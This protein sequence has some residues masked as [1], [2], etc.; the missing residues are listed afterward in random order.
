[1]KPLIL[2]LAGLLLTA[3]AP[4]R[5]GAS[6]VTSG[7]TNTRGYT[8]KIWSDGTASAGSGQ[9]SQ[10]LTRRFFADLRAAMH[11]PQAPP[12]ACMKSASFGTA[13][14]VEYHGWRSPDLQC[15]VSSGLV[16]LQRDVQAI[17]AALQ[18]SPE[19]K[20]APS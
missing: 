1:M 4:L 17:V 3:A 19:F 15:P 5:D 6:I 7:S 2:L 18:I 8:A 20:H 12:A 13:T 16:A 10:T 9:L 14:K 11:Q